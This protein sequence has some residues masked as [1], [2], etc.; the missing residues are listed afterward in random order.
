MDMI[1]DKKAMTAI[2][3]AFIFITIIGIIAAGMFILTNTEDS[4]NTSA[5]EV[6]DTFFGTRLTTEDLFED[7]DTQCAEI[8]DL[9]AAYMMTRK[10]D[11]LKYANDTLR[12]IVPPYRSYLLVLEYKG[13]TLEIGDGGQRLSSKYS[14]EI[15]IIDGSIMRT[16]L[17]LY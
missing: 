7:T 4:G 9:V 12:S 10:G 14:S 2:F 1:N 11:A 5:K 13:R 15:M 3:D 16:T 8:C 6:H 17:S